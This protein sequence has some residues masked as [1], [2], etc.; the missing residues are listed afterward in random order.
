MKSFLV[1]DNMI[2]RITKY[3]E[4]KD[5]YNDLRIKYPNQLYKVEEPPSKCSLL[6]KK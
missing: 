5:I 4:L 1:S 6:N 3:E 2:N